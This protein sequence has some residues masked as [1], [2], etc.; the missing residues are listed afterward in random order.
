KLTRTGMIV[1]CFA[2]IVLLSLGAAVFAD[3]RKRLTAPTVNKHATD[4]AKQLLQLLYDIKGKYTL[5]GQHNFIE[6]PDYWTNAVHRITGS[7]PA[8][9][10]YELGGIQNQTDA[11][12]SEQRS[13]VIDNAIAWHKDGGIVTMT[14]HINQPGQC[15]CWDKI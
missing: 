9:K 11:K 8:V 1:T 14:Y 12:L 13:K 6:A 5:A 2:V 7:M 15:Y 10:G 4:S 3:E